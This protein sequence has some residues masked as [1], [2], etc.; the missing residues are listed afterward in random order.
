LRRLPQ[1]AAW[2]AAGALLL[3][4]AP[5]LAMQSE[6][7]QPHL[8][9]VLRG[10][11]LLAAALYALRHRPHYRAQEMFGVPSPSGWAIGLAATVTGFCTNI[12]V[13]IALT[14]R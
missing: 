3:L 1:D 13:V 14:P 5:W 7:L 10:A 2:I 8:R 6:A 12:A 11:G 9:F 4:I